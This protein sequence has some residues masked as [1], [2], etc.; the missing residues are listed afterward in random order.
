MRDYSNV[1]VLILLGPP[2]AGKG[3]QA[4]IL[5]DHFGL[6]QLSTGDLLRQAVSAGTDAGKAA[7]SVMESGGLVS[8]EIVINILRD[9]LSDPDCAAGVILDG[10]PRTIPQA[11]ALSELLASQ[12]TKVH[13]AISL[14][15]EDDAM[16]ERISGRYTCDGC[17]EGYHEAFKRPTVEG[18]C[19][20]CG[21]QKFRRRADDNPETVRRRLVAYHNETAPL[22]A[23]YEETGALRSLDA[24][25]DIDAI[26]NTLRQMVRPIVVD[27]RGVKA[28][29]VQTRT[30]QMEET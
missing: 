26:T 10:F 3:T 12:G 28:I 9:R 27:V 4:K 17:G 13:A 20:K 6:V 19:D 15:V 24:M 21:S 29:K 8:D 7:K 11:E 30:A 16:V 2:G 18:A 5:E 22:I 23:F 14:E 1:P 25:G